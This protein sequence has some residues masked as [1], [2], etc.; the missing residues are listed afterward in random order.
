MVI[1]LE[2]MG[3]IRRMYFC[4]K[5]SLHQ[6]VKRTRRQRS[7]SVHRKTRGVESRYFSKIRKSSSGSS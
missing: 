6:I 3:N 5:P 7:S 1:S 4:E 2:M